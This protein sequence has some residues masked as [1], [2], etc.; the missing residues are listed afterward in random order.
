MKI[1]GLGLLIW[2]RKQTYESQHL[3]STR[4][5]DKKLSVRHL[6]PLVPSLPHFNTKKPLSFTPKTPQFNTR[7]SSTPL[8]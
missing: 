7:L 5:Q 6:N 3:S 4:H 8:I 1:F 2:A